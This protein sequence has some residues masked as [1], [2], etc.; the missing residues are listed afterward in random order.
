MNKSIV[1][2]LS[3][4]VVILMGVVFYLTL[5]VDQAKSAFIVNQQVFDG[6]KGK[7]K[8]EAKLAKIQTEHKNKLDSL[9]LRIRLAAD[10]L[11]INEYNTMRQQFAFEEEQLS[12]QYTEDIWKEI[13]E[14]L[15]AFGNDNGYTFIYGA[16]GN[17]SLMFGDESFNVTQDVVQYLNEKYEGER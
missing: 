11:V 16:T 6:F 2:G 7:Q 4:A 1:W 14:Q 13:N 8:L 17:G 3:F 5:G 12:A 15:V 9:E 10:P